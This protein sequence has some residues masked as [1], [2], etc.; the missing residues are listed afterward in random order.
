M[1]HT[2][3]DFAALHGT[4]PYTHSSPGTPINMP[5]LGGVQTG[6]GASVVSVK[7][8]SIS[9]DGVMMMMYTQVFISAIS[10]LI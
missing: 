4:T 5:W 6:R 2:R 3:D 1:V 8:A 9:G 7:P 10:G